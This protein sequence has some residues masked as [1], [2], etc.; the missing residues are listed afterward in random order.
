MIFRVY[1]EY[2]NLFEK[3]EILDRSKWCYPLKKQKADAQLHWDSIYPEPNLQ[4]STCNKFSCP[5]VTRRQKLDT[6]TLPFIIIKVD[7]G[8][9]KKK[10][11]F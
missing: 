10:Q 11:F 9:S 5:I 8:Y 3:I 2:F 7:V 1:K 6:Q 4:M